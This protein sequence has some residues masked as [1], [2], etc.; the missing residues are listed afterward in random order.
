[1][2]GESGVL[3]KKVKKPYFRCSFMKNRVVLCMVFIRSGLY[4]IRQIIF[5]GP[6]VNE[7]ERTLDNGEG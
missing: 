4:I 5:A 1:M 6:S 3:D 2:F 7:A